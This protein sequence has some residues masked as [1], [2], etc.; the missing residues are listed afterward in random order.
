MLGTI[1]SIFLIILAT[2][3]VI[4]SS[5]GGLRKSGAYQGWKSFT[6]RGKLL[7]RINIAF[8]LLTIVHLWYSQDQAK[9]KEVEAEKKE[10]AKEKEL[11]KRYD[12]S[13]LVMKLKFDTSSIKTTRVITE[14]LAKYGF[15]LDSANRKLM[16]IVRD[17]SKNRVILPDMPIV[18]ICE[19]G[20]KLLNAANDQISFSI[21]VCSDD[22]G[23]TGFELKAHAATL[24]STGKFKYIKEFNTIPHDYKITKAGSSK[25]FLSI[26]A[27]SDYMYM[28]IYLLGT[29]E[30]LDGKTQNL[31]SLIRY[32][33]SN[34]LTKDVGGN[35][36]DRVIGML[37]AFNRNL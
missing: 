28:Y 18:N 1:I 15:S 27:Q 25:M 6:E 8:A 4:I 37:R 10:T 32:N 14:T 9:R 17:S 29:Y 24:D 31:N 23:S 22:A 30:S 16:K 19:N 20:I 12:S 13:L 36:R 21:E 2:F 3:S 35:T 33:F 34:K 11:K 7:I 5:L 26:P